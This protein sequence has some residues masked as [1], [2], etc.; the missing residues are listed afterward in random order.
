[1]MTSASTDSI[2]NYQV[3]GYQQGWISSFRIR[4]ELW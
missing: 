3:E 2:S 1:M 4:A